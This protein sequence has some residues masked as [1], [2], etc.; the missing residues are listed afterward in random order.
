MKTN[1]PIDMDEA[2][3]CQELHKGLVKFAYRKK[4]DNSLRVAYGTRC[5]GW[6]QEAS[7][8]PRKTPIGNVLYHD[9]AAGALR[10]FALETLVEPPVVV[11]PNEGD[12]VT[13]CFDYLLN[14]GVVKSDPK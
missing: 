1:A 13:A 14:A 12:F 3:F 8:Q 6:D 4:S 5:W 10:S 11:V 2:T 9:M 7:D